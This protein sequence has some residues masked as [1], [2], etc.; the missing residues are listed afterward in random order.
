MCGAKPRG[1]TKRNLIAGW[2]HRH[3]HTWRPHH[4]R[5]AGNLVRPPRPSSEEE[6]MKAANTAQKGNKVS[7][8]ELLKASVALQECDPPED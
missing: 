1:T 4:P 5:T 2:M 8:Q 3:F 6:L 7:G